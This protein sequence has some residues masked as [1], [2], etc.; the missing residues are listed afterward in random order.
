MWHGHQVQVYEGTHKLEANTVR[1][2]LIHTMLHTQNTIARPWRQGLQ[3]GAAPCD[4]GICIYMT[5]N[6]PYHGLLQFDIP[7][8]R[9]YMGFGRDWLR[10][11]CR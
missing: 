3:L 8:H 10:M 11:K 6:K 1:T 4:D 7:R 9:L 2:V 5:C